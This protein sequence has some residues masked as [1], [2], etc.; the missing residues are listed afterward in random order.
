MRRCIGLLMAPRRRSRE[1]CVGPLI[2]GR[3]DACLRILDRRFMTQFGPIEIENA[4]NLD[5]TEGLR[6]APRPMKMGTTA[7]PWL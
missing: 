4:L 7:L 3:P 5:G 1:R 2:R 6:R